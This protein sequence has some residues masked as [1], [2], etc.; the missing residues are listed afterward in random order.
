M[1]KGKIIIL[2]IL[3]IIGSIGIR[4]LD[5]NIRYNMGMREYFKYN[6]VLTEKEKELLKEKHL[7]VGVYNDPP[8][9]FINEFNNYNTGIMVDYLSQ[10]EIE[11]RSNIHLKVGS[12]DYLINAM[13]SDEVDVM[14]ME[15]TDES[16][17]EFG[18]SEPLCV[19]KVKILVKNNSNIE[20]VEDLKDMALVALERD[21]ADGRINKY[22][23]HRSNVEIIEVDN[24]Y[25]CFALINNDIVVGFVGDDMEAAHFLNVTNRGT[26]FRF[27]ELT[28]Y[29]K[30]VCLAVQKEN[31]DLLNVL[32]K[33]ILELKKKNLIAQTQ[34]KWLGEFNTDSIDLRHIE[35]AY[36]VVIAIIFIIGIFSSWNYVITQRVNTKTRELSESKEELRLIIDTMQSGIMVIESDAII[37]ECN[38]AVTGI[39]NIPREDLIGVNY[40]YF[41]ALEP[42]VD[43]D[44]MNKVL[45]V[46]NAY[47]Y[48]TSQK[49]AS[50]KS[51]IIIE[52]YTEKYFNEKRAR[53]ESKMIAVG[54]LS[55][56]LAHEI[57]NPL[58][59]IKSYSYIIE[60]HCINEICDHAILVINDS[61]AR[62][63]KLIENLLRFSKLSNDEIKSVDIE[64]VLSLILDLEEKNIKQ[65][66]IKII[67]NVTGN[68]L[69]QVLINEDVL[70]MVLLNLINNSID[71]LEGV[72]REEKKIH[73][74]IKIEEDYLNIKVIDNGCGIEK[75][76]LENIFDPFYS[77]KENGTGL[78]LYIISTEISNNDGRISVES[79][80][81][82]GTGFDI[83]LPI[84]G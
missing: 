14:V 49:I 20:N 84:K 80:L 44:N 9:A 40:N 62:I 39:T 48:V 68:H 69:K 24:I 17:I 3:L 74:A 58:G 83:V 2:I 63:N 21:N 43:K 6:T 75:E 38:D 53:Q 77:T 47:Y 11:L 33:G 79:N 18:I 8:L 60:K 42:F 70:K 50:N 22:F 57:R 12:E 46:G 72:D 36:K 55:A 73:V 4:K 1:K 78:G 56:G 27:L 59:L 64:S 81:G 10:L 34:Y 82:E 71:S 28:L 41:K 30:E 37:V 15:N 31:S 5:L 66:G 67:S 7:L 25:Q 32:N 76:K 26:S 54:Q 19:V 52:N 35:L 29:E 23:E 13:K 51:M 61:V 16:K 65:N 45:N